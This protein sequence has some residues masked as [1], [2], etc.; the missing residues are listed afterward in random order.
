MAL[1]VAGVAGLFRLQA[2]FGDAV[3]AALRAL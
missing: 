1:L 2:S 3:A